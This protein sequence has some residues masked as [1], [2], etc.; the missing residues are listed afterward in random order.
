[1]FKKIQQTWAFF[2]LIANDILLLD[3][4]WLGRT[5][6]Y[7]NPLS[8]LYTSWFITLSK[9]GHWDYSPTLNLLMFSPML[10]FTCG[11]FPNFF[12]EKSFL[13]GAVIA[14]F[15]SLFIE[16]AQL[17]SHLGTFQISDLVYNTLSGI[18]GVAAFRM[19]QSIHLYIK[20]IEFD[21]KNV[22]YGQMKKSM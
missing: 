11:L 16:S 20:N 12:K 10:F 14:F 8:K 18:L 6:R 9:S 13:K 22:G 3:K 4:A 1:M 17:I 15:S 21:K 7:D 5:V 2:M 19:L